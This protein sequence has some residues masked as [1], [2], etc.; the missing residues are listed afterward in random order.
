VKKLIAKII[1]WFI[2]PELNDYLR[3]L[4]LEMKKEKEDGISRTKQ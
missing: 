1:L 4:L 2:E 3:A